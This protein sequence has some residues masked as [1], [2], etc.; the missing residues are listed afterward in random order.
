MLHHQCRY[1]PPTVKVPVLRYMPETPSGL[2]W[3]YI[4]GLITFVYDII[5]PRSCL[6][7]DRAPACLQTALLPGYRPRSCL[8]TG[9]APAWLQA[10]LLPGY[11]PRSCLSTDRAPAWLQT[12][13]LPVNMQ[14]GYISWCLSSA[15]VLSLQENWKVSISFVVENQQEDEVHTRALSQAVWAPQRRLFSLVSWDKVLEQVHE[16]G[17]P[18]IKKSKD[19]P[20]Y[21]EVTEAAKFLLDGGGKLPLPLIAKLLKFQFL[22]IK[23]RDLQRR[24]SGQKSAADKPKPRAAKSPKGK[25]SSAKGSAKGKGKKVP[26]APP[27]AK[28][29]TA[30]K[31]RGEEED[32]NAY[33]DDE[34]DDGP[35]H[36]IIVLGVYH[37]QIPLLLADLG[38]N[39]SSVIRI[40]SQNYTSLPG[41]PAKGE[42]QPE[43]VEAET[44]RKM[45]VTKSLEVFWKYLEPVLESRKNRSPLCQIAQLQHL[46]KEN[47]HPTDWSHAEQQLEYSTEVFESVACLM[48]DCLDWR[49]QHRHY[50]DNMQIIHVPAVGKEGSAQRPPSAS[51]AP[52]A[53]IPPS[54][55]GK[56]KGQAD[57]VHATIPPSPPTP[58]PVA[59]ESPILTADVDMRYY[60]DLLGDA[61][62][63]LL[64]VPVIMDCML[65]QVVATEKDLVPPSEIIPDPRADGLDPAIASHLV[66]VLDSL[67]LSEKEKKNLYNTFLVQ[68]HGE[69]TAPS[70]GPH[71]LRYHDKTSER[72]YQVQPPEALSVNAAEETM[73]RKLPIAQY[74]QFQHLAPEINSR[75]L[76]QIHELMHYCN[77]DLMPWEAVTRAFQLL[78]FESLTLTGFD[79][80]G[81]LEGPGK[82][83]GGDSHIPWDDP[84]AFAR[85]AHRAYSVRK[86]YEKAN[87]AEGAEVQNVNLAETTLLTF[88]SLTLTGFDEIGDLEGPGK[89]LGGDSHIPWDD[90]AAF[91]REAHRAYS[92]RKMYEKANPAEGA[93]VQNVNLAETT[94]RGGRETPHTDLNDIQKTRRR[95]LSDWC[96]SEH[97]DP[98][99]LIQVLQEAT[100]S[101]RCLDSYYHT[102]DNSLLL[103]LHNP[104]SPHRQSQES[105]DMALHSNVGFRNYL[106]FVSDS[107]SHWVQEEEV[108]YQERLEKKMEALRLAQN[109]QDSGATS[110]DA[111]PSKKGKGKKSSSPKKSKSPKGSKSR[112]GSKEK[113]APPAEPAKDPFIREDSLK[114]WKIEQDR[115]MEEERLKQEKKN[116]KGRKSSGK[117]KSASK[118]RSSSRESKGSASRSRK[119]AKKK[120]EK[121]EVVLPGPGPDPAA[122]S[123]APPETVFKFVGYDVGDNLIQVSGGCRCLYPTDGGQ[124]QVEHTHFEKG[125][126]FVKVK[127]L[128]D[129]HKFL[130]HIMNPKRTTPEKPDDALQTDQ[131]GKPASKARSV[132][133]FG[134][135]SA[136]LQSGIQLSV[137]HYGASGRGTEEK[138]PE[139]EEMLTFPSVHTPSITPSPPAQPP[140]TPSGKGRKSPRNKS[141]RAA[142]V[143]TPQG[144]AVEETP[145]TPEVPVVPVLPPMTPPPKPA[146][147]V[148]AFQSLNVSYPNGL[149][150]TFQRDDTEG[151]TATDGATAQ[152]LLVRQTYPIRVRNAQLYKGRKTP[153]ISEMSRIVT[154]EGAVVKS[155]LDG[156]TEVLFPGGS[157]SRSPDS[158]PV[159]VPCQPVPKSDTPTVG[160]EPAPPSA[161]S[162]LE[163]KDQK[164][165][166]VPEQKRGKGGPKLVP[167]TAKP[168]PAEAPPPE[169]LPATPPR[170]TVQPGTWITTTPYGD[171]IGTRGSER[172]DLRPLQ[173]FKATDPVNGSV[174][175]TREDGVVMVVSTDGTTIVEHVDGTRITTFYQNVDIPL[176][177]DHEE[178]GEVPQSITKRVKFIRVENPEFVT[179][180]LNCEEHT[181]YAVSGD[182][183]EI[184]AK[185]QAEYQ[186]FP[187]NSG[188]LSINREGCAD[189][190]PRTR[191]SPQTSPKADALPPAT[192]ILSH[193]QNVICEVMDP[194]GNLFQVNVDGSTSVVIAAG[195]AGE[196]E[197]EEEEKIDNAPPTLP[198]LQVETFDLHAPRFFI[199]HEDGSGSE[200]L[201]NREV[202][203]YLAS[204]YCEPAMAVL[205]E[206]TQEVPGVQTITVLQ[207][208]S[209]TSPWTMK[210]ELNS[211]VPPNLLSRKWD[212]FPSFE[213]KTPGP[214]LGVGVWKGLR[215]G[216]REVAK[217]RP[218]ILKCPDVLRIRQLRQY[219]PINM[220]VRE[221]LELSL[222]RY[223]DKVL[224]KEE[225]LQEM[226]IK[227]PR[228]EEEK[229]NAADLLM[230]VLSLTESRESPPTPTPEHIHED[231]ASLYEN[232]VPPPPPPPPVMAKPERSLEDWDQLRLE[233]QEQK[234][235]LACMRSRDIPPYFMSDMAQQ[236]FLN[237]LLV[238]NPRLSCPQAPD[239]DAL[240]KQVPPSFAAW[241]EE[242]KTEEEEELALSV[243]EE[244]S[245]RKLDAEERPED[246]GDAEQPMP[247]PGRMSMSSDPETDGENFFW[248]DMIPAQTRHRLS[249]SLTVDVTGRPRREKVKL[250]MSI[251]SGKPA[252]VPNTKFAAVEDPVRR[253]VS[254]SSTTPPANSIPRGFHLTPAVAQF[255][256]LREGYTYAMTVIIKNI[257]VDFCR[258]RVKPPPPSSGLRVTY[259]PGPVA[260][261]MQTRLNL[262]LFAMAI[263]LDGPEG[264]AECSHCIEIQSE[265]ETLFLPIT[266]TVFTEGVYESHMEDAGNRGLGPG[267]KLV[268]S[269]LQARVEL[270]RSRKTVETGPSSGL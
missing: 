66:S 123:P 217:V 175:T 235:N 93:E 65:E 3:Y 256:T 134:S 121:E 216:D 107:I 61:P 257:G 83:L 184:L 209:Q 60:N 226:N 171:Q 253:R 81:D 76:A 239:M 201:R 42:E 197:E 100:E 132:S 69:K 241:D 62:E 215:I 261:G 246:L 10:A 30:L 85:E 124:I 26:E 135:F 87:P 21:Y 38:V 221:K 218:P 222:K 143:K 181:C 67:S 223:I 225:E 163:S 202:E 173:T 109:T 138:D 44:R 136:T 46:V 248:P 5:R 4:R 27:P 167:P 166:S 144:P 145:R 156:S 48:Y 125:S 182:G 152:P 110:R 95:C 237:Q 174:V 89:I 54:P 208:F 176:P 19:A 263:G 133:E 104:M 43:A 142:R 170:P 59:V 98:A 32:A 58:T 200:L 28:T 148:P 180:I 198:Q 31:R 6:S 168:E 140:P 64:T 238:Y 165:E 141:P 267:V 8:A 268:S 232:A 57:E 13:L 79:E 36:Y 1:L 118:E 49:R 254:T 96:Y 94:V 18:K 244:E 115:L 53:A 84:A 22:N 137:S 224:K 11:R 159:T 262:E 97:F 204:C 199:V 169:P 120:S 247:A 192:Y 47:V 230:L 269:S 20:L 77:T 74:L 234:D 264:A 122:A 211:I 193:T 127:L 99:L 196:E 16:L 259:T 71:L 179:V 17:N 68:D 151:A 228:T 191:P 101:Y 80:I 113:K 90:P 190:C 91:A 15:P 63:E 139:L 111:S 45:A 7:T 88:E 29:D 210:K 50:L 35:Q 147:A 252:S 265:V 117:K 78:T 155:M 260:A 243:E 242:D 70:K 40:S 12:A 72:T 160:S 186:V 102:Q 39:V 154:P 227:E 164:A 233:I 23:Q 231:I 255:G 55:T 129:G 207:P 189:Y 108:M 75:R 188:C 178:T 116:A 41:N 82:I 153:G 194:E 213:R 158:G 150:V 185:P 149:L 2:N 105:W 162:T 106:E 114:A 177:G 52:A 33:I 119:G 206:P 86:M 51:E 103:I 205:R 187:P 195:E 258:F 236:F 146:P 161:G 24:E 14:F 130:V 73:L 34:P 25:K 172:L 9:R 249:R 270:L 183:T 92:V 112:P 251:L 266:A 131:S 250:P 203:D 157:V 240:S 56:R 219:E 212:T 220:E 128:K 214:P 37:P 229:G 245:E 126:S